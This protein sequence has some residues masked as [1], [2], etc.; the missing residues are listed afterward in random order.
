LWLKRQGLLADDPAI[1]EIGVGFGGLIAMNHVVGGHR[2]C[3]VDLPDVMHCASRF[4]ETMGLVA[5]LIPIE[6]IKSFPNRLIVSNYAFS[7]LDSKVQDRYLAEYL[8]G[9]NHGVIVSNAA[10]FSGSIGGRDDGQIV[11]WLRDAGIPAYVDEASELLTPG[12]SLC[13]VR[14]IRW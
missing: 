3:M 7:E 6:E 14:M 11:G 2:S 10:V 8:V 13:G 5:S 4:L 12:D 9:S 1:I